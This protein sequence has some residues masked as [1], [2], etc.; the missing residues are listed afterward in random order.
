MLNFSYRILTILLATTVVGVFSRSVKKSTFDTLCYVPLDQ[1][2]GSPSKLVLNTHLCTHIILGDIHLDNDTL[3]MT[4]DGS[5]YDQSSEDDFCK[6]ITDLKNGNVKVLIRVVNTKAGNMDSQ[7]S[8][9]VGSDLDRG[10]F[11][12]HS[13][14]FL[15]KHC[16]DGLDLEW[17]DPEIKKSDYGQLAREL[18]Q[19]F[20]LKG[21][22]VSATVSADALNIDEGY[23]VP[24]L[25]EHMDWLTI[26]TNDYHLAQWDVCGRNLL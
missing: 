1:L 4:F 12:D 24:T 10:R 9:L 19:A 26:S 20:K 8:R 5:S 16:F 15:Q 3:T 21:L 6:Q 17:N 11:V 23:D 18:S 2:F 7:F 14:E 13:I 22:L 25:S